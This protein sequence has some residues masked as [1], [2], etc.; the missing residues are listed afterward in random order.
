MLF[1]IRWNN[2]KIGVSFLFVRHACD[3]F[4][5]ISLQNTVSANVVFLFCE[6]FLSR[7]F[8]VHIA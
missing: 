6:K 2:G 3:T 4:H 7:F 1:G 8:T 5:E